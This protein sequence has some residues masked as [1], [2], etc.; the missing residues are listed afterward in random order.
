MTESEDSRNATDFFASLKQTLEHETHV[1]T[2]TEAA[3][4]PIRFYVA[5]QKLGDLVLVPPR[6]CHQ[7][8]NHGGIT[9]KVS[10]SRMTFK[11]LQMALYH[12]LPLYR[13]VCRRETYKVKAIIFHTIVKLTADLRSNGHEKHVKHLATFLHLFDDI[14]RDEYSPHHKAMSTLP[15]PSSNLSCDFCGADIFHGFLHC[16]KCVNE[17]S[18]NIVDGFLLCPG[19]FV[20]GRTCKCRDLRPVQCQAF[21]NLLDA[22][23]KAQDALELFYS[24]NRDFRAVKLKPEGAYTEAE[25]K[26]TKPDFATQLSNL[27]RA[28]TT[29]KPFNPKFCQGGWYDKKILLIETPEDVT[30]E[31][32][33][34]QDPSTSQLA[35]TSDHDVDDRNYQGHRRKRKTFVLDCVFVGELKAAKR[36]K[37]PS[38]TS[39]PD[40][41]T[42]RSKRGKSRNG[43]R[44]ASSSMTDDK[45]SS[46]SPKLGEST[47]I[48]G[49]EMPQTNSEK[50]KER[51]LAV[52]GDIPDF[53]KPI[54]ENL[55]S[56]PTASSSI[57]PTPS[58]SLN[59]IQRQL[60][61]CLQET[62]YLRRN[63]DDQIAVDASGP[64]QRSPSSGIASD[65]NVRSLLLIHI[66]DQL[67]VVARG[68]KMLRHSNPQDPSPASVAPGYTA[69]QE[70]NYDDTIRS[71]LSTFHINGLVPGLQTPTNSSPDPQSKA[72]DNE[73]FWQIPPRGPSEHVE[74]SISAASCNPRKDVTV[75]PAGSESTSRPRSQSYVD[76]VGDNQDDEFDE[77]ALF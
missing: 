34:S 48:N 24:E 30:I 1:L 50:G 20:E 70:R 38:T 35:A 75:D 57:S 47:A 6:S 68:L 16:G 58:D 25:R 60:Y 39:Q 73:I 62:A 49:N 27:A 54:S 5:E 13:R 51:D 18:E 36:P 40:T 7:V 77:L 11:G 59:D 64:A 4:A 33:A 14:L 32:D 31:P 71:D 17:P 8:V 52:H 69:T 42:S 2:Y 15:S 29:C 22:R 19:C 10:W 28:F 26:G 61:Q 12:E 76:V 3:K 9:I 41:P 55:A 56:V 44:P 63:M 74:T 23:R 21:E 37:G 46:I 65:N 66:Q 53:E 45:N 43:S 72:L 67:S